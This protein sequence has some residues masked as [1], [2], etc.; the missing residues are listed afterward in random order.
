[1]NDYHQGFLFNKKIGIKKIKNLGVKKFE[2]QK[3]FPQ[4]IE[5][6]RTNLN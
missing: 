4:K 6:I 2:K 1:V 3:K 5:K